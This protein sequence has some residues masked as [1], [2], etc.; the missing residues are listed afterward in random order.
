[1]LPLLVSI[2]PPAKTGDKRYGLCLRRE[3]AK[4]TRAEN[5]AKKDKAEREQD[6]QEWKEKQDAERETTAS[7]L[8]FFLAREACFIVKEKLYL[9]YII[10]AIFDLLLSNFSRSWVLIL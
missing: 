1:M 3:R 2:D 6:E 9:V 4:Q 10:F 5:R 7:V 8:S